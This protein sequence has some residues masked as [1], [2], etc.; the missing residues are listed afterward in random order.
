MI[1]SAFNREIWYYKEKIKFIKKYIPNYSFS[2]FIEEWFNKCTFFNS[3]DIN[4]TESQTNKIVRNLIVLIQTYNKLNIKP[5][6]KFWNKE[7]IFRLNTT[8]SNY[9]KKTLIDLIK[10]MKKGCIFEDNQYHAIC[11]I[12]KDRKSFIIKNKDIWIEK[13][14]WDMPANLL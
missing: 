10:H 1:D 14:M 13:I 12:I 6:I 9:D 3:H 11:E 5:H 7:S 2:I 8:V 4:K